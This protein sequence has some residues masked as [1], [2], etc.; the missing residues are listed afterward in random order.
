MNREQ[1]LSILLRE[2]L[3]VIIRLTKPEDADAIVAALL[4]GGV[5]AVEITSNTPGY[6]QKISQLR[7]KHP[8][9]L[10]G[11]GTITS[12][13]L[14][15]EA[16]AAG[17]QFLVTPNTCRQLVK[18]AHQL[19]VPAVMGAMTPTD[20]VQATAAGADIVKLFPS[21][22]LGPGYLTSLAR[23]PFIGTPFFPV[24][25]VDEHNAR[26]WME[27]GACGVGVGGRLAAPVSSPADA[28]ALT[29]KAARIVADLKNYPTFEVTP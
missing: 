15:D 8:E 10:I 19:D 23:G 18:R 13:A 6:A 17:A 21:G 25:G 22:E 16:V 1:A 4:G 29:Q 9:L 2:K 26:Q 7:K 3:V 27:A 12:V 11:A 5:K 24:G 20:V 28:E 14:A